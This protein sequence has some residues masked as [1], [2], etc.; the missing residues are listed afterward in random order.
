MPGF[1]ITFTV[2]FVIFMGFEIS[3]ARGRDRR[4]VEN[5]SLVQGRRNDNLNRRDMPNSAR[6]SRCDV[7]GK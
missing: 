2:S 3:R 4:R 7:C 5:L 1:W 6:N